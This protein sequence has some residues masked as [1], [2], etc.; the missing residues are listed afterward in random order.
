MHCRRDE[1]QTEPNAGC[2]ADSSR[3]SL[4]LAGYRG[5]MLPFWHRDNGLGLVTGSP[6]TL[7]GTLFRKSVARTDLVPGGTSFAGGH[8][9]SGFQFFCRFPQTAGSFEPGHRPV[10]D[11]QSAERRRDPP[12]E[13]LGG[14]AQSVSTAGT[15]Q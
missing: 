15:G 10:G 14:H 6:E 12:D 1:S 11:V 3:A 13:A 7:L 5:G 2:H 9:L 8:N 4:A